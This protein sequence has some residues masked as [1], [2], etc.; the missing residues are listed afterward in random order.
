MGSRAK[1]EKKGRFPGRR[2]VLLFS[3]FLLL[4]CSSIAQHTG[5][6]RGVVI[7]KETARPLPS[8]TVRIP[9]TYYGTYTNARGEFLLAGIQPGEY[10]LEIRYLG[11]KTVHHTGLRVRAGD[12]VVVR[13]AL[14]EEGI[15]LGQEVV[16]IGKKPLVDVEETQSIHLIEREHIQKMPVETI[17][18][19]LQ[20]QPGVVEQNREI[21][22]RGSRG[23]EVA[24][25]LDGIS[26][27]DP[28]S[29]TGFGLQLS[30]G[31]VETMEVIT[32]GINPEYGQ[33]TAGVIN[34]KTRSGMREYHG[35]FAVRR[36]YLLHRRNPYDRDTNSA[37]ATDIV[38]FSVGGPEPLTM[39]LLPAIGIRIPGNLT[40]FASLY[41]N[42]S[43]Y[44]VP[45]FARTTVRSTLL[46]SWLSLRQEN[47]AN[48]FLKVEWSPVATQQIS[49]SF[50]QSM[51]LNQNT[52]SLQ[53]NLEYVRPDPGYQYEFQGHFDGA[54]TYGN[55]ARLHKLSWITPLSKSLLLEMRLSN[56][57]SRLKVDAN[58][59]EYT[60]YEPPVDIPSVPAEYY[61]TGDSLRLGIIPGDGFYD[62][63]NGYIWNDHFID[64]WALRTDLTVF[65]TEKNRIKTGIEIKH[66][67]L[68]QANIYAPWYEP[69]GL[70]NDV[71]HVRALQGA[72]Y[73]QHNLT[74][75]GL[76]LN[77]GLRADFWA[78]GK[79]VDRV[80]ENPGPYTLITEIQRQNYLDKTFAF[81]G[82]RWKM[83]LNPRLG[84]SHPI[85]NNQTLFFNF[86]H[87]SKLPRP[88]YVYAKLTPQEAYSSYQRI[89]NPDLDP[90]TSI[91]YEIG[92]RS[93]ITQNDV[94][95]VTAYYKDI[96]NYV[97]TQRIQVSD[98]RFAGGNYLTYVNADYA[99][100][101]G[102]E[103]EFRKRIG[104]WFTG[105]ISLSYSVVTG[106]SN[107]ADEGVLI[108]RGVQNE[109][110]SEVFL[111]WD[112][113]INAHLFAV[114]TSEQQSPW[115]GMQ[116]LENVSFSLRGTFQSGLRYTPYVP[117][118]DPATGEQVRLPNGKPLYQADEQRY[119]EALG[120]PWWW[121]DVK[122]EKRFV[123]KQL[124][125]RAILEIRNLFDRKNSQILNPV[126][127]RAYEYGDPTPPSW[128]DPLYPQL[129]APLDPYPFN[130]A[131]Y[132]ARR[133]MRLEF[134]VEF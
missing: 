25:L 77:Y 21:H 5:A 60:E 97:Q 44:I 103:V 23:Y 57:Y 61:D 127:G 113:P 47:M 130:P 122:L 112:R 78:P 1:I 91:A 40:F 13:I 109:R 96:F 132:S 72:F 24:Y 87:F 125:I 82:Y 101:R 43:D 128:N 39:E 93:Q 80:V 36:G 10:Q 95:T 106:K 116:W 6:I 34:I 58:G 100:S 117:V 123:L 14:E 126:T 51:G 69:L 83:R 53:T 89:G 120:D 70:N 11:Y 48:A 27:Q 15:R 104:N 54:L 37:Y 56:F 16:V 19:V 81:L 119:Y 105:Q 22:I 115:F 28:L 55:I 86:G 32:G 129:Q 124:A 121:I 3:L 133:M 66:Q 8:A 75:Q 73:I 31:A 49:Y 134:V 9:G 92:M 67:E 65:F 79:E 59:K 41:V 85:T 63:G 30:A 114:F 18:E 76:I 64:E 4:L 74:F 2:N 38:E 107:S 45:E 102:I 52:R 17:S 68:Q 46:P 62:V 7:D 90:E 111:S 33:T 29:G 12:T 50:Y 88:Q 98:L 42:A 94:L 108:V 131:R 35:S 118:R 110:L 26:I 71:F 99:R 20:L 84:I